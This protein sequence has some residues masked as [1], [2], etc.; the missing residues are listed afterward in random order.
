MNTVKL[1]RELLSIVVLSL[2]LMLTG[3]AVYD[4]AGFG[5]WLAEIDAARFHCDDCWEYEHDYTKDY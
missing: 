3:A 5:A 1:V 4:P 2:L